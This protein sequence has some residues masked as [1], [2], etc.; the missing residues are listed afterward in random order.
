[1]RHLKKILIAGIVC[2]AP[3]ATFAENWPSDVMDA[4]DVKQ[5][6]FCNL[7]ASYKEKA[8]EAKL[9]ENMIK[10]MLVS[11]EQSD[12]LK[13]LIRDR[14]F[15]NWV[16]KV[17]RV[18]VMKS[19]GETSNDTSDDNNNND[20]YYVM[21]TAELSCGVQLVSSESTDDKKIGDKST[22]ILY[23][24]LAKVSKGTF[25]LVSGEFKN[26]FKPTQYCIDD[27]PDPD[28]KKTCPEFTGEDSI[29]VDFATTYDTLVIFKQ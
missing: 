24:Q 7:V 5:A 14:M 26:D 20:Q 25:V 19:S 29:K 1:M 23:K 28:A 6:A 9:S 11:Q 13:A 8:K 16:A 2:M 27:D 18:D 15:E 22:P 12:D 10:Q 4:I 3:T 17:K 21:L